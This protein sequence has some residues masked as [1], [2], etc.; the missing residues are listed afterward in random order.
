L[1]RI[2]FPEHELLLEMGHTARTLREFEN[3]SHPNGLYYTAIAQQK[4]GRTEE[5]ESALEKLRQ[6]AAGESPWQRPSESLHHLLSG[7]LAFLRGDHTLALEELREAQSTLSA[8]GRVSPSHF[9]PLHVPIWFSMASTY[10]EVGEEDK[11][12]EWFERVTES[13]TEHIVYAIPY[14]R[15]FYFLGKIHE[16]RDE[17]DKAREYYRRFYEYWKDGDLDRERVEEAKSKLGIM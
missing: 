4:L 11:A 5:A 1:D 6:A 8:H 16:S 12:A 15:S 7:R 13:T 14:V 3:V 2:A 17:M 10:L 9:L